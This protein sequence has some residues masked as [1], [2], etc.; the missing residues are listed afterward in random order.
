LLASGT[1]GFRAVPIRAFDTHARSPD[2]P[3][4]QIVGVLPAIVT[5]TDGQEATSMRAR[6]PGLRDGIEATC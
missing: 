3:T 1:Q 4:W 5:S 6:S 2:K